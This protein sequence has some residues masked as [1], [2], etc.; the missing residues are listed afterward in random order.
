MPRWNI[1]IVATN[2]QSVGIPAVVE[3]TYPCTAR[4]EI[5]PIF[6][7]NKS[8]S[9]GVRVDSRI[10]LRIGSTKCR[11]L[12]R[13]VRIYRLGPKE[14]IL[15]LCQRHVGLRLDVSRSRDD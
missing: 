1:F 15:R 7:K 3:R 2:K 5:S 6:D 11:E 10:E 4:I 14:N 13:G 9:S 12:C 8:L